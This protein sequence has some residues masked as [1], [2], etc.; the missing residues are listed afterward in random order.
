MIGL[1]RRL[2]RVGVRKVVASILDAMLLLIFCA[3]LFGAPLALLITRMI[4][5]APL[6]AGQPHGAGHGEGER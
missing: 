5:V 4:A 2:S 6:V 3:V 1:F